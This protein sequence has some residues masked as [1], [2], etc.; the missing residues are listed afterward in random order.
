MDKIDSLKDLYEAQAM[1][2]LKI[3]L[4]QQ[5]LLG[6]FSVIQSQLNTSTLLKKAALPLASL[7]AA[8]LLNAGKASLSHSAQA[9]P[10]K[11]ATQG[12]LHWIESGLEIAKII[13]LLATPKASSD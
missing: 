1:A 13:N 3:E 9:I 6:Q 12:W 4:S 11:N 10:E 2:K 5:A 8:S 7:A